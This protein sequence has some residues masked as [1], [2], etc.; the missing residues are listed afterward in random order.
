MRNAHNL[1]WFELDLND[2]A[3][4]HSLKRNSVLG[5]CVITKSEMSNRIAGLRK[6]KNTFEDDI[7]TSRANTLDYDHYFNCILFCCK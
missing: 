2:Q 1:D 5:S 7:F 6:I 3:T 4:F